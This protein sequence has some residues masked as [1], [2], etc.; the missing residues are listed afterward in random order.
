MK[1]ILAVK[2]ILPLLFN[3]LLFLISIVLIVVGVILLA[4]SMVFIILIIIG[5]I[6]LIISIIRFV[7]YFKTPKILMEYDNKLLYVYPTKCEE[8]HYCRHQARIKIKICSRFL[9][10]VFNYSNVILYIDCDKIKLRYVYNPLRL[11][12]QIKNI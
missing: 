3:I 2:A 4:T 9:S 5:A 7:L 8:L 12:S 10:I 6:L 1:N 11:E